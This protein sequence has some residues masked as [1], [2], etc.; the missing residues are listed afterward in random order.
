MASWTDAQQARLAFEEKLL[1]QEFPEFYFRDRT[2]SGLTTVW[3]KHTTSRTNSYQLAIWIKS[4][5][6]Y[7]MPGLYVTDPSP[8]FGYQGKTIQSYGTSHAM[9]VWTPDWHNFVKICF[10]KS[11]YWSASNTV[12][13]IIMKALLW[14]EAFEVHRKTGKTIDAYSLT[15]L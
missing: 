2:V 7:E 1:S 11:E 5:F 8:L 10:C 14:L 15:Y 13:S 3:G 9:H 4:G 12:V 6:P